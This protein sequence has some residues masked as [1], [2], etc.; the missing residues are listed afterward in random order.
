[1]PTKCPVCGKEHATKEELE[2]AARG[3]RLKDVSALGDL[4]NSQTIETLGAPIKVRLK[5]K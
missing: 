2:A 4:P 1:M 3:M 5:K